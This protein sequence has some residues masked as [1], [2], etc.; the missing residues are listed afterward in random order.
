M[1]KAFDVFTPHVFGALETGYTDNVLRTDNDRPGAHLVR[2]P[3]SRGEAGVRLDTQLADHLL[4]LE[5]RAR[6]TEYWN[7]SSYDTFEHNARARLDLFFTDVAVHGNLGYARNQ[8]PQSIQLRG[9]I[10]QSVYDFQLW[11]Q[12]SLAKVGFRVGGSGELVDYHNSSLRNLDYRSL[13]GNAQFFVEIFPKLHVL[14]EYSITAYEY[15]RGRKGTLNDYL[16]HTAWL[17]L[18][19][20][21]TPKLTASIKLG[22]SYQDVQRGPNPDHR[23]YQGFS[24]EASVR[25]APLAHTSLVVTGARRIEP[26]VNSNYLLTDEVRFTASQGF[27][28]EGDLVAAAYI[29]YGH[30]RVSPGNHLNRVQTGASLTWQIKQWL[31]VASTYTF[32]KLISGF[33]FSDYTVHTVTISVGV[34]F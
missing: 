31:S 16:L 15:R 23:D 25:W 6:M 7:T 29:G 30:S 26:S 2:E 19:G 22:Y 13:G 32:E 34:G 10:R 27:F 17:G 5:Y 20:E 4:Q 24:G 12:V 11:T 14:A 9:L 8:Y 33:A 21:L 3:Y 28:E 1:W 18:R